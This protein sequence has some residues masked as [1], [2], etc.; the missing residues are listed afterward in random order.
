MLIVLAFLTEAGRASI[1]DWRAL[2]FNVE[3]D[4]ELEPFGLF[5]LTALPLDFGEASLSGSELSESDAFFGLIDCSAGDMLLTCCFND[6]VGVDVSDSSSL[7]SSTRSALL[8]PCDM[9]MKI[10]CGFWCVRLS[11]DQAYCRNCDPKIDL[12]GS[13]MD[14]CSLPC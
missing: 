12:T 14:Q 7:E 1:G 8:N 10:V 3:L 2:R 13:D 4:T 9:L 11:L 6:C 5:E